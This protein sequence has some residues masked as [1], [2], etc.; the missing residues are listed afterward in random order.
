MVSGGTAERVVKRRDRLATGPPRRYRGRDSR[1]GNRGHVGDHFVSMHELQQHIALPQ[2]YGAPAYARPTVA[3]AQTPRPIDPDDLP[4]V[5][6][7][8][9]EDRELF[10]MLPDY[11]G[12]VPGTPGGPVAVARPAEID[13]TRSRPFSLR[14]VAAL[15]RRPGA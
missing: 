13:N 11:G 8:S 5:A 7:M 15:I 9:E 12:R 14:A 3:V 1:P 4:I 10:R 2:L 6:Q